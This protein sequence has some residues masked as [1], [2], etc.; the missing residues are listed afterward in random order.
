MEVS[1]KSIADLLKE[2]IELHKN[3]Q[4]RWLSTRTAC[5]MLQ[6]CPRTLKRYTQ[7]GLIEAKK[8]GI[9]YFYLESSVMQ[10]LRTPVD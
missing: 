2:L 9:N 4:E 5:H 7:K 1:L 10:Y 8:M 6:R 3:A